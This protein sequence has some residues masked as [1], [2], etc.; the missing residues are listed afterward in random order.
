[1]KKYLL[2]MAVFVSGAIV[3]VV[4]ITASRILAPYIGTSIIAWSS[5]LGVVLSALSLGYFLGGKIADKNPNR[6]N[7]GFLLFC[8]GVWLGLVRLAKSP[9]LEFFSV[10]FLDLRILSILA[11]FTLFALPN[12]LLGAVS[13]YVIRLKLAS[14]KKSGEVAGGLYAISTVGSIF[15]TFITGFYLLGNLGSSEILTLCFVVLI[16]ISLLFL[17]LKRISKIWL[18]LGMAGIFILGQTQVKEMW[19]YDTESFFNKIILGVREDDAGRPILLLITGR[20]GG[21]DGIQSGMYLDKPDELAF[22]YAKYFRLANHFIPEIKSVL[23]IGGGGYS[24]PKDFLNTN[25]KA[26]L[27]V[28]EIDPKMTA[29]AKQFFNLKDDPRLTIYHQDG[30]VYLNKNTKGYD[31]IFIDTFSPD[32]SPPFQM[33]TIEALAKMR[34]GLN[35]SGIVIDNTASRLYGP[36]TIFAVK[37]KA[38][39]EVFDYVYAFP[40]QDPNDEGRLQNIMIIAVKSDTQPRLTSNDEELKSYLSHLWKGELDPGVL[41]LTD[42]FAPLEFLRMREIIKAQ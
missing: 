36:D 40:V 15:G 3:M 30:R 7:L 11:S 4:E 8:A 2:E 13:P 24:Y 22:A 14:L 27:D 23:M 18:T 17:P 20:V 34:E 28:V 5:L 1:M 25:P 12:I 42:N 37:F 19:L 6:T 39:Q 33:T 16:T 10:N 21:A 41:L 35:G 38:Y 29:V 31:A 26:L 32:I 9:V